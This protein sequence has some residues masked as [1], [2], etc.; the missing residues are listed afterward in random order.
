MSRD[1]RNSFPTGR[2]AGPKNLGAR[3]RNSVLGFI[4]CSVLNYLIFNIRDERYI[5][6]P[7]LK[8]LPKGQLR[9]AVSLWCVYVCVEIKGY[10][11]QQK[12][13]TLNRLKPL[14]RCGSAVFCV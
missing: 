1:E 6:W 8:G 9:N 11:S 2:V 10:S 13:Q 12:S 5:I 14:S 4:S 7:V 3:N